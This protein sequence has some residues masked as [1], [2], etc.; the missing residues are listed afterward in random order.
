MK[1]AKKLVKSAYSDFKTSIKLFR[2]HMAATSDLCLYEYYLFVF[3]NNL[4]FK[5][6]KNTLKSLSLSIYT[7]H[8]QTSL[9]RDAT[10]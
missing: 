2:M 9:H 7:V 6:I 3:V 8:V 1:M 4:I 10:V 5:Q